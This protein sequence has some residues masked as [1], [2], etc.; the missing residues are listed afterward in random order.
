[1]RTHYGLSDGRSYPF[2]SL[3]A[4]SLPRA[5]LGPRGRPLNA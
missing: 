1:M 5:D 2:D 4:Q 3:L